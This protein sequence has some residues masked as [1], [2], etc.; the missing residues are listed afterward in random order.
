MFSALKLSFFVKHLFYF[1][2]DKIMRHIVGKTWPE[3]LDKK[4][5]FFGLKVQRFSLFA[6]F[7]QTQSNRYFVYRFASINN[8][9]QLWP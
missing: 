2:T 8:T 5:N 6:K 9:L 1:V 4:G 3:Y 7:S